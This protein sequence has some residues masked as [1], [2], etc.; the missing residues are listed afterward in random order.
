M[1]GFIRRLR[2]VIL[3]RPGWTLCSADCRGGVDQDDYNGMPLEEW[4]VALREDVCNR[5]GSMP[6]DLVSAGKSGW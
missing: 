6:M 5:F 3:W 1:E 2:Q 4:K